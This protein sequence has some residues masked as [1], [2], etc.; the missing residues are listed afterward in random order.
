MANALYGRCEANKPITISLGNLSMVFAPAQFWPTYWLAKNRADYFP[1]LKYYLYKC[2]KRNEAGRIL[3]QFGLVTAR[4]T[5]FFTD[6]DYKKVLLLRIE[7]E[8]VKVYIIRSSNILSTY[9]GDSFLSMNCKSVLTLK[10]HNTL[11]AK[12]IRDK[13][14][15]ELSQLLMHRRGNKIRLDDVYWS[16]WWI[17]R[18][19]IVAGSVIK[20]FAESIVALLKLAFSIVKGI[21]YTI[22]AALNTLGKLASGDFQAV[23]RDMQRLVGGVVQGIN[24]MAASLA[25]GYDIVSTIWDDGHSKKLLIAFMKEYVDGTS[26]V[27]SATF[28]I[29]LTIDV[30]LIIGT[31]GAGAV[32]VG[33]RLAHRVG[34]FTVRALQFIVELWRALKL[35]KANRRIDLPPPNR[36]LSPPKTK[37]SGSDN[38]PDKTSDT[39]INTPADPPFDPRGTGGAAKVWTST[40]GRLKAA[41]LP[42]TGK[43]RFVPQKGY[44]PSNPLARGPNNGYIDRFGNEWVRGPSR[45]KGQE[46][47]WD[48]QLS[49]TGR[50]KLGW[51]T[52]DGSHANVSLDGRFTHR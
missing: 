49:K 29:S 3:K 21:H 2:L 43:I 38:V 36:Q 5:S 12:A 15:L 6:N 22:Q 11:D 52:R 25:K 34:Q 24:T 50:K 40:K 45:T 37:S 48:V 28:K 26:V 7:H 35:A 39:S 10:N 1:H 42:T 47:E 14:A 46:F 13:L 32:V 18:Q 30:I 27:D 17:T 9:R 4:Q 33:A 19:F 44:N 20:V 41:K 16:R 31:L 23:Q 51:A 8:K